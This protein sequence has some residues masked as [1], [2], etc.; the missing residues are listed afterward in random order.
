[1]ANM[2][3]DKK[4]WAGLFDVEAFKKVL[5]D[6]DSSYSRN[7]INV[8]GVSFNIDTKTRE[9]LELMLVE[10]VEGLMEATFPVRVECGEVAVVPQA[11]FGDERV[12]YSTQ[13]LPDGSVV[14]IN[15]RELFHWLVFAIS[16]L[17]NDDDWESDKSPTTISGG[18]RAI[19]R[20]RVSLYCTE[21]N[22]V[23]P[24]ETHM[25]NLFRLQANTIVLGIRKVAEGFA[26]K[27][28][29]LV[30]LFEGRA[31][32]TYDELVRSDEFANFK[33]WMQGGAQTAQTVDLTS[34]SPAEPSSDVEM[35]EIYEKEVIEISSSPLA[36]EKMDIDADDDD[37]EVQYV[38]TVKLAPPNNTPPT[39][40]W[41]PLRKLRELQN[42]LAGNHDALLLVPQLVRLASAYEL[43]GETPFDVV[44]F[45]GR[46]FTPFVQIDAETLCVKILE[47]IVPGVLTVQKIRNLWQLVLS[48]GPDPSSRRGS[49]QLQGTAVFRR[50]RV[51]LLIENS[52]KRPQ[53]CDPKMS[54][55]S[56]PSDFV[57][58]HLPDL[59]SSGM[60][61][62]HQSASHGPY[63]RKLDI[64]RVRTRLP[65]N[66]LS[67]EDFWQTLREEASCPGNQILKL[68]S[69]KQRLLDPRLINT[70]SKLSDLKT[71]HPDVMRA[72]QA[73]M[74]L[75]M[76]TFNPQALKSNA[77]ARATHRQTLLKFNI[78]KDVRD[79]FRT[80]H[81]N[82]QRAINWF[83]QSLVA[84]FGNHCPYI[85][86]NPGHKNTQALFKACRETNLHVYAIQPTNTSQVCSVCLTPLQPIKS[87]KPMA[88]RASCTNPSCIKHQKKCL[89]RRHCNP[90]GCQ[91]GLCESKSLNLFDVVAANTIYAACYIVS[92][93]ELPPIFSQN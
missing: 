11:N 92:N 52:S 7:L 58:S 44:P 41:A 42:G 66:H 36:P 23:Y 22:H 28:S 78:R 56:H 80:R 65:E 31:R 61:A 89:S 46:L 87:N 51:Q 8:L 12:V 60:V 64:N 69:S 74:S 2:T 83:T 35:E 91:P 20:P 76:R 27:L 72:E 47:N 70:K 29:S 82:K 48:F 45:A 3:E 24:R 43:A 33:Q 21:T 50:D 63:A 73:L 39:N 15:T 88:P 59:Y 68:D 26:S 67:D 30:D 55:G 79:L 5:R 16:H 57:P 49:V 71:D 13:D 77:I 84:K 93:S 75:H 6:K 62:I 54:V 14:F 38:D 32:S 53:K 34:S 85:I 1:M 86:D 90:N 9:L 81:E 4:Y 17:L 25:D 19:L 10:S 18:L 37:D 40:V